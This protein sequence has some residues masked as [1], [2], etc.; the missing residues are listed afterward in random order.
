METQRYSQVSCY[1]L[2]KFGII[3]TRICMF[4]VYTLNLNKCYMWYES[5]TTYL[6]TWRLDVDELIIKSSS[7]YRT[8]ADTLMVFIHGTLIIHHNHYNSLVSYIVYSCQSLITVQKMRLRYRVTNELLP[9]SFFK[10][11]YS[12]LSETSYICSH[13]AFTKVSTE[14]FH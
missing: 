1:I 7:A 13:H 8:L 5:F 14:Y 6:A 11:Q 2:M 9:R 4:P 3:C 12:L 10:F